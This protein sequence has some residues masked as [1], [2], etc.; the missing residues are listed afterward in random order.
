MPTTTP[1]IPPRDAP[2]TGS[3]ELG[4][5]PETP[6]SCL[7]HVGGLCSWTAV[8]VCCPNVFAWPRRP[9]GTAEPISATASLLHPFRLSWVFSTVVFFFFY[10]RKRILQ[11]RHICVGDSAQTQTTTAERGRECEVEMEPDYAG[12]PVGS[13]CGTAG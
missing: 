7:G 3:A 6:L 8:C 9:A 1:R 4:A 12:T 10:N 2:I 11:K 13:W 5:A